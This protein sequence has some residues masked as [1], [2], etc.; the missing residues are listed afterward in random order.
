[1][2]SPVKGNGTYFRVFGLR[3]PVNVLPPEGAKVSAIP[4]KGIIPENWRWDMTTRKQYS[5]LRATDR[6][7]LDVDGNQLNLFNF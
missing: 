2:T 7:E 1:V 3:S 4:V 6:V 5:N